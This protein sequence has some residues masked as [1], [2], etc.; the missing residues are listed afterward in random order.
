MVIRDLRKVKRGVRFSLPAQIDCYGDFYPPCLRQV[1]LR[2]AR[3]SLQVQEL[4]F[5]QPCLRQVNLRLAPYP[6]NIIYLI[7]N[8]M[9]TFRIGEALSYG[10]EKSKAHFLFLWMMLGVTYGIFLAFDLLQKGAGKETL[11]GSF[12]GLIAIVVGFIVQLGLIRIYLDLA[13][14]TKDK[15]VVLFSQYQLIWKYF[16]AALLYGLMVVFGLILFIIP[17]IYF[18]LKY[19]FYSYLIVDKN[20]SVMEALKRSTRMTSGIK[21][22]LFGF[23]LILCGLNFLGLIA[24]V[25]GLLVTVPMSIMAYV[26]VYR[27]LRDRGQEIVSQETIVTP[28][29]ATPVTSS[30]VSTVTLSGQPVEVSS[31]NR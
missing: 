11:L 20:L 25:F 19:Q 24:L 7:C 31:E 3:I 22:K 28:P 5:Y 23:S 21:W 26:Y 2:L 15:V 4:D 10:W 12:L 8:I 14:G 18:A 30:V 13:E 16:G 17:G 9:E 6:L 1:N 27:S 29:V